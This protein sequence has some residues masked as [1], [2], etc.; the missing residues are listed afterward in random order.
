V[1]KL[2]DI[3]LEKDNKLDSENP[4]KILVKNKKSGETYYINKDNFNTSIHEKP[5]GQEDTKT[6][7]DKKSSD[8]DSKEKT[9][10]GGID[11]MAGISDD[12]GDK[13][14]NK[15]P[16]D[17]TDSLKSKFLMSS[18]DMDNLIKKFKGIRPDLEDK[19][20]RYNYNALF[21]EYNNLQIQGMDD[22]KLKSVIRKFQSVSL[23]KFSLL[24]QKENDVNVIESTIIYRNNSNEIND[25]LQKKEK[26]MTRQQVESE[27]EKT[28]Q[29]EEL[30]YELKK[31]LAI[32]VMDDHFKTS[33]ARLEHP[34][35]VYRAVDKSIIDR[36]D[37]A[38]TWTDNGFVSTSLNPIIS[39]IPENKER[40]PLLKIHLKK[41]DPVL[42]LS[43]DEDKYFYE[44]EVTL[45]RKCRF[46]VGKYDK[47]KN[48]YDVSVE[49]QNA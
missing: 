36:F 10:T 28:G 31:T 24:S 25:I 49:Y 40:N 17:D 22:E 9:K 47:V 8:K 18:Y 7:D 21:D 20:L 27:L 34:V 3:L 13:D 15:K 41:G 42:I 12:A 2:K 37:E 16:T 4:D 1:I 19:L 45:P 33:G 39:E 48:S 46:K 23:A 11:L 32:Y 26:L 6:S 14:T 5:K 35:T 44:T 43:K 30:K 38:N 29:P